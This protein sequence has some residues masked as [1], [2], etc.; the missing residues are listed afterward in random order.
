MRWLSRR[1][2]KIKKIIAEKDWHEWYAWYPVKL[3]TNNKWPETV[4]LEKIY[5]RR[6]W[7][8]MSAY[9]DYEIA[10][11]I[12]KKSAKPWQKRKYEYKELFELMIDAGSKK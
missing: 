10:I 6:Q 4:W 8:L 9:S 11:S 3:T 12:I 5:R 7:P 1:D 2:R